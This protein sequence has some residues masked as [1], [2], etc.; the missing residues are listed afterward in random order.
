MIVDTRCKLSTYLKI[1]TDKVF[2]RCLLQPV[3]LSCSWLLQRIMYN[4]FKIAQYYVTRHI[5]AVHLATHG[6]PRWI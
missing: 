1:I 4:V 6:R 3:H 5:G 2:V